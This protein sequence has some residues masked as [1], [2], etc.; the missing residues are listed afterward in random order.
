MVKDFSS[1]LLT[2]DY[3]QT[4]NYLNLSLVD[5]VFIQG[6]AFIKPV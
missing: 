4:I 1:D 3:K 2:T 6:L 5:L